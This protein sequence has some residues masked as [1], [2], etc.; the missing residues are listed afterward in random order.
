[1]RTADH[2]TGSILLI[3][4]SCVGDAVMTTPVLEALSGYSPREMRRTIHNA[5]GN[6]KLA[7]RGEVTI[8]L[9]EGD[10]PANRVTVRI[11]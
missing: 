6:A 5:F 8:V 9:T 7:G 2:E 4:L 3:S 11:Q 1:M 10:T